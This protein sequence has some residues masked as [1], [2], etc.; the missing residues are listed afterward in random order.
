MPLRDYQQEDIDKTLAATRAGETHMLGTWPTGGGKGVWLAHLPQAIEME[1]GQQLVTVVDRKELV[2]QLAEKLS[3]YN[4]NLRVDVERAGFRADPNSDVVVASVQ[5]LGAADNSSGPEG[6][7]DRLRKFDKSRVRAVALDEA[8]TTPKSEGYARILRYFNCYKPDPQ[9]NSKDRCLYG[10]TAT[11][12]R[13]DGVGLETLFDKIVFRRDLKNPEKTG[14]METGIHVDGVLRPWL[15]G[16]KSY[17]VDTQVDISDVSTNRGDFT[18]GDLEKTVNTAS[19]NKLIVEKYREF[20]E[21]L[22]F[23]AFSVDVQHSN[24]LAQA[25]QD[26]GIAAYAISG[27]TPNKDRKRLMDAFR[28]GLIR[29]LISCGVLSTGIDLP[30]VGCLLMARPTKAKLLYI[31]QTGRGLRPFPAPEFLYSCWRRGSNPGW[32]KPHCVTIDF[33]DVSSR[34][35]LIQLPT[36]FGLKSSFDMKGRNAAE[37]VEEIERIKA[38]KPAVN[39]ALYDSLDAIKGVAERI[40]LFAVPTVD[41]EVSRHSKLSWVTGVT[42]GTYQLLLPDKGMISIKVN[43]L[44]EYEVAKHMTGVKTPLGTARDL[45]EALKMA[46]KNVPQEAMIVLKSDAGWRSLPASDLQIST[47]AKLYPEMRRTFATY[48][49]FVKMVKTQYSKGQVSQLISARIGQGG[50]SKYGTRRN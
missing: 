4:P 1:R 49:E 16:V 22:Q 25:F 21:G 7:N 37:V 9:Y 36:L 28:A 45:K 17:R 8:H 12:F 50:G 47:V 14:L 31:Q 39:M 11:A 18:V 30:M 19:R 2:S 23:F 33:V 34:H 5:T 10:L 32:I 15:C 6:Y 44:G 40:D 26:A 46:D 3:E 38:A 29:G 24:D 42:T 43:A 20:G 27:S 35:S 48:D 13:S 41:P